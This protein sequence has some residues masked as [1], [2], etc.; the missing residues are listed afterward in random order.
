MT[1]LY[2]RKFSQIYTRSRSSSIIIIVVVVVVVVVVVA[3]VGVVAAAAAVV[4]AVATALVDK[5]GVILPCQMQ[6]LCQVVTAWKVWREP[7][8]PLG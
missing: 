5:T 7:V 4:V 2:T 8:G 6:S 1:R 3:V